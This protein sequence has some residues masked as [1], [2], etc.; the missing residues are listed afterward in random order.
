[1]YICKRSQAWQHCGDVLVMMSHRLATSN[2]R[3]FCVFVSEIC[4]LK[5]INPEEDRDACV[6]RLAIL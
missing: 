6:V 3:V 4:V 2:K 1:M 5:V